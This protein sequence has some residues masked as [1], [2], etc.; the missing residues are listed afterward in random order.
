MPE[1]NTPVGGLPRANAGRGVGSAGAAIL[2][3]EAEFEHGLIVLS[4]GVALAGE[5]VGPGV[6]AYLGRGRDELALDIRDG[7]RVLLLGGRPFTEDLL[8]W[9]NFVARTRGEIEQAWSG[10]GERHGPLRTG[11]L[12]PPAHPGTASEL[13][14]HGLSQVRPAHGG[15]VGASAACRAARRSGTTRHHT[16]LPRRSPTMSPASARALV[17]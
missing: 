4:G 1:T 11:R 17:W 12:G 14:A 10:V 9:W 16:H 2:P 13:A 15:C 7:S 3:V 8:M 5:V 6:L